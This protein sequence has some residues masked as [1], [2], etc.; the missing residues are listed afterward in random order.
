MVKALG[1]PARGSFLMRARSKVI[2][3]QSRLLALVSLAGLPSAALSQ[4]V[5]TWQSG[6][7]G[8][9]F[10][11]TRWSTNPSVPNFDGTTS[12]R[13]VI[14]AAG[15]A[16]SISLMQN[17]R[18]ASLRLDSTNATIEHS[19]GIFDLDGVADL[20]RGTWRMSGG[21]IRGGTLAF[22]TV[23]TLLKFSNSSANTL[24]GVTMSGNATF[25]DS[26]GIATFRNGLTFTPDSVLTINGVGFTARFDGN[27][28][29]NGGRFVLGSFLGNTTLAVTNNS[30]L[31]LSASTII[32]GPGTVSGGTGSTLVNLGLIEA[33][34]S[35]QTT[36]LMVP[37]GQNGGTLKASAGGTL[38]IDG[39]H[40]SSGQV[41]ADGGTVAFNGSVSSSGVILATNNGVVRFAGTVPSMTVMSAQTSSGGAVHLV[42]L[43]ENAGQVF[44]FGASAPQ[45]QTDLATIGGG[46]LAFADGRSIAGRRGLTLD[47]TIVTGDAKFSTLPAS[48]DLDLIL[49]NGAMLT[50]S[51]TFLNK[52]TLS[53]SDSVTSLTGPVQFSGG[54]SVLIGRS[55]GTS[56]LTLESGAGFTIG[57]GQDL[58][59]QNGATIVPSATTLIN[60]GTMNG[61]GPGTEL[62]IKPGMFHNEGLINL[63]DGSTLRLGQAQTQSEP[64]R[65]WSNSGTI[66]LRNGTVQLTGRF[67]MAGASGFDFGGS[68]VS[69]PSAVILNTGS[70]TTFGA[71]G[72]SWDLSNTTI[73]GGTVRLVGNQPFTFNTVGADA[74]GLLLRGARL[75]GDLNL[76]RPTT[77]GSTSTWTLDVE[78]GLDLAGTVHAGSGLGLRAWGTQTWNGGTI[79]LRNVL[80]TTAQSRIVIG[81]RSGE[82]PTTLT[83]G[84]AMTIRGGRASIGGDGAASLVNYGKIVADTPGATFSLVSL[85]NRGTLEAI[86]GGTLSLGGLSNYG[87]LRVTGGGVLSLGGSV[88]SP[89]R[90]MEGTQWV[91]GS[92]A[93]NLVGVI[94]NEERT[95]TLDSSTGFIAGRGGRIIGGDVVILPGGGFNLSAQTV[96]SQ[97]AGLGLGLDSVSVTGDM[98]QPSGGG[99][100]RIADSTIHGTLTLRGANGL[101][102]SRPLG[103]TTPVT[104]TGGT[105]VLEPQGST[106]VKVATPRGGTVTLSPSTVIRGGGTSP[107]SSSTALVGVNYAVGPDSTTI[108]N[109]GRITADSG[110]VISIQ[111]NVFRNEGVVEATNGGLLQ[112]LSTGT[113]SWS[114]PSGVIRATGGGQ[115]WL[116]GNFTTANI[117][118]LDTAGGQLHVRGQLNNTGSTWTLSSTTSG[119]AYLGDGARITGGTVVAP[120]GSPI[121]VI[122]TT[123]VSLLDVNVNGDVNIGDAGHLGVQ[124]TFGISGSMY[125]SGDNSRVT[126][127]GSRTLDA[128]SIVFSG[129]NGV[130][131]SLLSGTSL[132]LGANAVVRGGYGRIV[133]STTTAFVNNGRISADVGGQ[134]IRI[135]QQQFMNN[136]I[137]EAINGG[138]I[139]FV[140]PGGADEFD[141]IIE[142]SATMSADVLSGLVF[143]GVY[144]Q[145]ATGTL[146]VTLGW[147]SESRESGWLRADAVELAGLLSVRSD[148]EL[149]LFEGDSFRVIRSA[150][151]LGS[152][153]AVRLPGLASPLRWDLDRLYVDGTISVVPTPASATLGL[154]VACGILGWRRRS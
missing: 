64:S 91:R 76:R 37:S 117:G 112:F 142:N 98:Y 94:D 87:T 108:V 116:E 84:S 141:S 21:T 125:L 97:G 48:Q 113:T 150:Q 104:L 102:L 80:G 36:F 139:V 105:I 25:A 101:M 49:K 61:G 51:A 143:T 62:T 130:E 92:G 138:Q 22:S 121:R 146:D 2:Q 86:G 40:T 7:S 47:G 39:Q 136:G 148:S 69:L 71:S 31:T 103:D 126:L 68:I 56:S 15:S 1:C 66:R 144:R 55:T 20:V 145:L 65:D 140:P 45:I 77:V 29:V 13:A 82:P 153:D 131:R 14:D 38:S 79:E 41:L 16:Y 114:N 96:G 107:G 129:I 9:W 23:P 134:S 30:A 6:T 5:A 83:I 135:Y 133:T 28:T 35:G 70:T 151:I 123:N 24:D 106:K 63:T 59:I 32:N 67:S 85:T 12:Y 100:L 17:L 34:T 95:L 11:A 89:I 42:G 120:D 128:G 50:G 124:G 74:T 78:N 75:E 122:N 88:A 8:S 110:R 99:E 118:S 152:F 154:L 52:G 93:V 44:T 26:Q 53:T 54:G 111:P 73:E 127:S 27:Q 72:H 147:T 81:S 90:F 4:T 115:V 109:Q 10:D 43:M 149:S 58:V 132:T 18:L 46:T 60:R 57:S 3:S 137:V 19:G 119:S 33:S